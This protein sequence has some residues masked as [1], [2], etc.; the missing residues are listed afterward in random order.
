MP[1]RTASITVDN[2]SEFAGKVLDAK[3]YETNVRLSFTR[4]AKPVEKA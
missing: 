2:G 1:G 3:A 4:P